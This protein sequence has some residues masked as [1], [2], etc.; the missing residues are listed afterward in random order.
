M[1]LLSLVSPWL[2]NICQIRRKWYYLSVWNFFNLNEASVVHATTAPICLSFCRS[3]I[4]YTGTVFVYSQLVRATW[5]QKKNIL[6]FLD[7]WCTRRAILTLY[8]TGDAC[9]DANPPGHATHIN[10]STQHR[11]GRLAAA[12]LQPWPVN[13]INEPLV[14]REFNFFKFN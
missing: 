8:H 6:G 12:N 11:P 13:K 1:N 5:R 2:D 4:I 7:D 9:A 10:S 14:L 3:S